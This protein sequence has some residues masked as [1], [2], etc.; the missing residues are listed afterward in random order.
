MNVNDEAHFIIVQLTGSEKVKCKFICSRK[1]L[2]ILD[3]PYSPKKAIFFE[4]IMVKFENKNVSRLQLKKEKKKTFHTQI[5]R[6]KN[7][8]DIFSHAC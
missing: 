7:K 1:I 2:Y 3:L 5:H 4:P 6:I 8:N